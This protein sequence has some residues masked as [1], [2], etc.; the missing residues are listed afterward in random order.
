M[1]DFIIDHAFF[2]FGYI[3][4]YVMDNPVHVLRDNIRYP[5][6]NQ[7]VTDIAS[8]ATSSAAKLREFIAKLYE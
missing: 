5:E 2:D 3:Y 8:R 1:F 4:S 6:K 7:L